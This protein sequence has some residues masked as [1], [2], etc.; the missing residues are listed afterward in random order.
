MMARF[1]RVAT[2]MWYENEE[3]HGELIDMVKCM[4]DD[5]VLTDV[6]LLVQKQKFPCHRLVLAAI[7]PFFKAMFTTDLAESKQQE[8]H[9]REVEAESVQLIIAYAYTGN[10]EITRTNAESLLVAASLFQITP[11]Q[12]ACA[13]FMAT[14]LDVDNYVAVYCIAHTY[15]CDELKAKVREYM[16]KNFAGVS[17]GKDFVN[18]T[19][20]TIK[21]L[22]SSNG[23]N[24]DKEVVV[25]EAL[26]RWIE[27]DR[28][29][30]STHLSNLLPYLRFGLLG[31]RYIREKVARNRLIKKCPKCKKFLD[32]L[33]DFDS[34]QNICHED[35]NFT[36][37]VRSGMM[38]PDHC[39]L[40][41]I[42]CYN[43]LTRETYRM[44]KVYDEYEFNGFYKR[45]PACVV[46]DDNK[47][48]LSGGRY[49]L[50]I[51]TDDYCDESIA[52][53]YDVAGERADKKMKNEMSMKD[54]LQYDN[55]RDV[56]VPKASMLSPK[57]NYALAYVTGKI[58]CFGGMTKDRRQSEDIECY[59][60]EQNRWKCVGQLPAPLVDLSTIVY[61]GSIYILGGRTEYV[62]SNVV[63]RYEP[64]T[65]EQTELAR[66]PNGVINFGACVWEDE[67]Y[68]AGGQM[69]GREMSF[70]SLCFLQIYNIEQNQWRIGVD[71]PRLNFNFG[72]FVIDDRLY[73][74][75]VMM[76]D[77]YRINVY[78]LNLAKTK[79]EQVESN[80]IGKCRWCGYYVLANSHKS[81]GRELTHATDN[82]MVDPLLT[83]Y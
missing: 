54:L 12:K 25:Y 46:T 7:S 57:S 48:F 29:S 63:L 15:M 78:K 75:G 38:E 81:S 22:I 6:S 31:K 79:W 82:H 44:S 8:I 35:S 1:G 59:D 60:I 72:L 21:E 49:V 32:E 65:A 55:D 33:I 69:S 47:I 5:C 80:L 37:L 58:Y 67:I 45:Y 83:N 9:L 23:L 53:Y 16:K 17:Q 42:T 76:C 10:V 68:I 77:Q 4:Y 61:R 19:L 62:S 36:A 27:H 70:H 50:P 43:T 56:W 52:D 14:Q 11:I 18:L 34:N 30:R 2:T 13:R 26:M 24:V 20:D 74:C 71:L 51:N 39:S 41:P 64:S 73:A 66:M 3:H 28:L 40:H